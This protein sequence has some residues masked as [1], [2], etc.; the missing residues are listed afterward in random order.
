MNQPPFVRNDQGRLVPSPFYSDTER[1]AM[2]RKVRDHLAMLDASRRDDDA[3]LA[4]ILD[5]KGRITP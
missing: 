3:A 2:R 5:E 4:F 1:L